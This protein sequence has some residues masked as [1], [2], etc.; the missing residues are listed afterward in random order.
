METGKTGLPELSEHQFSD[1]THWLINLV[2]FGKSAE[3]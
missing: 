1:L 3:P 2:H